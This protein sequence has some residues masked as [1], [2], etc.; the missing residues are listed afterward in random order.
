MITDELD[1]VCIY[2]GAK[3]GECS[4]R[5]AQA[6][7]RRFAKPMSRNC[8]T[9]KS[10]GRCPKC[11]AVITPNDIN[12]ECKVVCPSCGVT[13]DYQ[14]VK[15]GAWKVTGEPLN[16]KLENTVWEDDKK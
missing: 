12:R 13:E 10:L 11:R 6:D 5:R 9:Y 8:V 3:K 2:C 14:I 1:N 4:C 7:A 15:A 16:N